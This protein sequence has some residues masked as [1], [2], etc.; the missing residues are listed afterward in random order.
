MPGRG[1]NTVPVVYAGNVAAGV[2]AAVDGRGSGRAFNQD[3]PLTQLQLLEGMAGGL[4][5]NP[6]FWFVPAG[7]I[8]ALARVADV[9]GMKVP[10][11]QALRRTGRWLATKP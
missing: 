4:G 2:V 5:A 3:F 7:S 6:R 1:D 10:R 9:R 11:A 8:R